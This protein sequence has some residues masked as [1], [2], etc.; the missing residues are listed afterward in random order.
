MHFGGERVLVD[1]LAVDLEEGATLRTRH[2]RERDRV[3]HRA[4]LERSDHA[5]G[6]EGVAVVERK[7]VAL[8]ARGMDPELLAFASVRVANCEDRAAV[9]FEG[10]DEARRHQI[11]RRW[12]A[13]WRG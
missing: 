11:G 6:V 4:V 8:V 5:D 3:G 12:R 10:A 9:G 13:W 2:C 7:D 1:E